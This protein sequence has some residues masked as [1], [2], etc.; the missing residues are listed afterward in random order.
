MHSSA[1]YATGQDKAFLAMTP[2]PYAK[3]TLEFT[4]TSSA[5]FGDFPSEQHHKNQ[6]D[7]GQNVKRI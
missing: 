2:E 4:E 5:N 3:K 6:N 7:Y 1:F